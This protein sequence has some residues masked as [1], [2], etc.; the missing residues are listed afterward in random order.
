[1]ARWFVS[2]VLGHRTWF[3]LFVRS[4]YNA[5]QISFWSRRCTSDFYWVSEVSNRTLL[6]NAIASF[7]QQ[8][9]C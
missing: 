4:I 9:A 1:M 8:V 3:M 5:M 6:Y 7:S 2:S